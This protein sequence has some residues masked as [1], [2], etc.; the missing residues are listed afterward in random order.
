LFNEAEMMGSLASPS[1]MAYVKSQK[2]VDSLPLY[3]Q[4]QHFARLGYTLSRQTMTNWIIYGAEKWLTP[5]VSVIKAFLLKQDVLH[6]DETTLQVLREPGKSAQSSSYLW[7][8]RTGRGVTPAVIY[9]YQ[10]TR[11]G[12]HP[13]SFLSGFK[14]YLHV[15]GY[16]GY[17]K[18]KDVTLVGCWAH[19]RRKYDEA[20]KVAPPATRGNKDSVAN[21]GLAY[22]NALFQM[23]R[24]LKDASPEERYAERKK[25][26]LSIL[27]DY[28]MWLK[29][30]RS[31]SLPKSLAGQAGWPARDR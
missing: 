10:K 12:E 16:A 19:A 9:D 5:L 6:A 14:D 24:E 1:G 17:Q 3:R 27:E 11:S 28:S 31:Q 18:V 22:C 26:S 23:E 20:L 15:N 30:Q 21:Q 13:Q 25:R 7:L 29:Q 4:E 2:Y 8:Y